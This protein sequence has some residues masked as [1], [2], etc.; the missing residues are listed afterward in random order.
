MGDGLGER[1]RERRG[2]GGIFFISK[3]FFNAKR[4]HV[5]GTREV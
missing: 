1:K 5:Q 3:L 2:G 4:L